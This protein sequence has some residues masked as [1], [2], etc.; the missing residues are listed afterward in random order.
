MTGQGESGRLAAMCGIRNWIRLALLLLVAGMVAGCAGGPAGNAQG[1]MAAMAAMPVS[2]GGANTVSFDSIDGP[3]PQVFDRF[4]R[5]L[6]SEAQSRGVTVVSRDGAAGYRVRSYL[7]AQVRGGRTTIAWVWDVY[8]RNQNRALRL[9]G[10]EAGGKAGQDAWA[11]ADEALLR[12]IAQTG[13]ISLSGFVNGTAPTE[14]PEPA[15]PAQAGP[16]IAS[17]EGIN[18]GAT[19]A[20]GGLALSFSAH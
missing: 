1:P 15:L 17:A 18:D 4:V 7:A 9:T 2:T 20:G 8:D 3:P 13:L 5:V 6:D 12:R 16:A 14:V 10:E 19:T 11:V